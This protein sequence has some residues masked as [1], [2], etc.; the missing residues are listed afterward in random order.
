MHLARWDALLVYHLMQQVGYRSLVNRFSFY[1]SSHQIMFP[2]MFEVELLS[3][4]ENKAID[5]Y[6]TLSGEEKHK[7]SIEEIIKVADA[8]REV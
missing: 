7:M 3:F 6:D 8:E 2:V 5:D 1:I 4:V